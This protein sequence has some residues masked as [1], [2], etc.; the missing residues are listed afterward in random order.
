LKEAVHKLKEKST[1]PVRI[2]YLSL[3]VGNP[4]EIRQ[5]LGSALTDFANPICW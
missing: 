3:D 2:D 1:N 5:R 4:E